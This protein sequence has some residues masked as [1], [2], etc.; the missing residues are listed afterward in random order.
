MTYQF[1]KV[2]GCEDEEMLHKD[3]VPSHRLLS[4][5]PGKGRRRI[6]RTNQRG[7]VYS[8]SGAGDPVSCAVDIRTWSLQHIPLQHCRAPAD[9][10]QQNTQHAAGYYKKWIQNTILIIRLKVL[11]SSSV[12]VPGVWWS[13]LQSASQISSYPCYSF[14]EKNSTNLVLV[15]WLAAGAILS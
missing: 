14:G 15:G 12:P 5:E 1:I 13:Q 3:L 10:T 7:N 8:F 2:M 4:A 6:L 9:T 11:S